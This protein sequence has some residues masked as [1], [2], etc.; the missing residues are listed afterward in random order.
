MHDPLT[1]HGGFRRE[2]LQ[3]IT[4]V[5]PEAAAAL[6]EGL[7]ELPVLFVHGEDDQVVQ[8][9]DARAGAARLPDAR[10]V[11]FPG[12]LHDVLNEHDRE[13]VHEVVADFVTESAVAPA[14]V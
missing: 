4:R 11:A 10:I 14:L 9:T 1:W 8:V 7:P 13:A 3:A 6:S 5:W 2:T 12:D